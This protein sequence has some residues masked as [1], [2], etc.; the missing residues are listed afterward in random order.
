MTGLPG[1]DHRS[2]HGTFVRGECVGYVERTR[3]HYVENL[4]DTDLVFFSRSFSDR[5]TNQDNLAC[6]VGWAHVPFAAG[7]TNISGTG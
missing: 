3:P 1:R 4:G 2:H 5:R 6:A 7:W